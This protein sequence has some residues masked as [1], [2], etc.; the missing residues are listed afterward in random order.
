MKEIA[1]IQISDNFSIWEFIKSD[2]AKFAKI[3]AQ[4]N[5]PIN[6]VYNIVSLTNNILQPLRNKIGIIKI[7]S[8]YRCELLNHFLNGSKCSQHL[9]GSAADFMCEDQATAIKLIKQMQFDQLII[10][11]RFLHVSYDSKRSR[12]SIFHG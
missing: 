7:T 12:K 6:A 2:T 11:P 3:K 9:T 5:I 4:Y 10:Y 8:G 1:D